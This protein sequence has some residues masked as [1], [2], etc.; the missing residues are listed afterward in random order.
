[1]TKVS[2]SIATSN[3]KFVSK[4]LNRHGT[5]S[6]M[7]SETQQGFTIVCGNDNEEVLVTADQATKAARK[8]DFF[9]NVFAHGTRESTDRILKKPDW[10]LTTAKCMIDLVSTG[11]TQVGDFEAYV[12]LA[13]AAAQ[14]CVEL[15]QERQQGGRQHSYGRPIP[16]QYQREAK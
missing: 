4:I 5:M 3:W 10:S 9:R 13:E 11:T 14:M 16:H 12:L 8:C 2:R 7:D 1:M 15:D 6:N